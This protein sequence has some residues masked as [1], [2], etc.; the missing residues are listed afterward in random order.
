MSNTPIELMWNA[1]TEVTSNWSN[2]YEKTE[3]E[4]GYIK[5]KLDAY[6]KDARIE[7]TAVLSFDCRIS[8]AD[9]HKLM[10]ETRNGI[11]MIWQFICQSYQD[12]ELLMLD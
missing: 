4:E 11:K 12:L 5:R 1:P 7:H 9:K 3:N 6:R 8:D 10:F 2:H